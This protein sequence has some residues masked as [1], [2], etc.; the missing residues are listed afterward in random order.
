MQNYKIVA[1]DLDG[2]LLDSHGG[3]SAE[4]LAAIHELSQRGVYFVPSSGRSVSEMPEEIREN[5]DIRFF[6]YSNGA[7]VWDRLTGERIRMCI[8]RELSN[9]VLD[10][11]RSCAVHITYRHEGICI[12]DA[13]QQTEEAYRYFHVWQRHREV[14]EQYAVY[15]EDFRERSYAADGVEMFA[16]Y[17]HDEQEMETCRA[18]LAEMGGLQIAEIA[19]CGLEIFSADAGK[20]NALR[21]LADSMG[22][23][24][25]DT[26]SVGDSD[27]DMT[28]TRAAGLGLAVS[29][30]CEALREAADAVICSNDAHAIAYIAQHYFRN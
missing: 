21:K 30:A 11:L 7:A 15:A 19:Y 27:N 4:N 10:V 1:S 24:H 23:A 22:I 12:A 2:T 14:V 20:G 25:E 3:I 29:N 13:S 5:P 18:R 26:V 17:F 8:P 28:I 6:I 9:R 16:V